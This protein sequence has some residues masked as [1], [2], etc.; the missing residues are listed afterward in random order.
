MKVLL[1]IK[2]EFASRIFAGSKKYEYRRIIFKRRDVEIAIVY[3]SNPIRRVIG[4]FEIGE[5]LYEKPEQLWAQ[6]GNHAGIS[7]TRF[8]EYFVNHPKGY[9]IGIRKTRKYQTPLFLNELML[10][11]PPQSFMYLHSSPKSCPSQKELAI[12][13]YASSI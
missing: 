10:S 11:V 4:E 5:I 6:T 2:P 12:E 7:K 3:A 8:M 13:K 1:S 9:A